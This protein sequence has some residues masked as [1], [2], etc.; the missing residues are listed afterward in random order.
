V[1]APIADA[2]TAAASE[3]QRADSKAA[4]GVC[5]FDVTN[6]R[7]E[8]RALPG[9]LLQ[10]AV[11]PIIIVVPRA[12]VTAGTHQTQSIPE[13]VALVMSTMLASVLAT[14]VNIVEDAAV[15]TAR[16]VQH[17]VFDAEKLLHRLAEEGKKMHTPHA[18]DDASSKK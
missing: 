17:A 7:A 11:P 4:I 10:D 5:D 16:G 13:F 18:N 6:V 9:S 14:S 3:L 12:R 1:L 8:I 2:K 15:R